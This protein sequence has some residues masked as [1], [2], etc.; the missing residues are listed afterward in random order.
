[1]HA[2]FRTSD[3]FFSPHF[4]LPIFDWFLSAVDKNVSMLRKMITKSK[5]YETL[6]KL[7]VT[8]ENET[9]CLLRNI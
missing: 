9:L 6:E 5:E 8:D 1:M 2:M 4:F 7:I 3:N